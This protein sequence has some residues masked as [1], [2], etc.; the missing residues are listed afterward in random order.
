ML[1][2]WI[3]DWLHWV[4]AGSILITLM[5]HLVWIGSV[6]V[7][8]TVSQVYHKRMDGRVY[9]ICDLLKIERSTVSLFLPPTDLLHDQAFYQC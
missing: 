9:G 7:V 2:D 5:K 4:L 3:M 6:V 1:F 8:A